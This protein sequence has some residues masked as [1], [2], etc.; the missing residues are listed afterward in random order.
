MM[1]ESLFQKRSGFRHPATVVIDATA[2]A[3][4][5]TQSLSILLRVPPLL[6]TPASQSLRW[7]TKSPQLPPQWQVP[8]A[9]HQHTN[10]AAVRARCGVPLRSA[11]GGG[12]EG[13]WQIGHGSSPATTGSKL[14]RTSSLRLSR[15]RFACHG[16][17]IRVLKACPLPSSNS[18]CSGA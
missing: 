6:S 17:V 12:R 5:A 3:E 8:R 11:L 1:V 7:R 9:Q 4:T 15:C 16:N 14:V 2:L 18:A 13:G 10:A